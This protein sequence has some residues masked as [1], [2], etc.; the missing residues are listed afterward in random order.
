MLRSWKTR[1]S[2]NP[3]SQWAC[4]PL[5]VRKPHTKD[6]FRM[7][8]NLRP[9]NSQTKQIAS[10]MSMLEVVVDHLRGATCFSL[11]DFIKGY[12]QFALDPECQEIFSF[13]TDTGIYVGKNGLNIDSSVTVEDG[14]YLIGYIIRKLLYWLEIISNSSK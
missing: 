2:F 13:L 14:S 4:A 10:P 6:E 9:V 8:V 7:T 12:W 1:G 3:A 11:L 5:I